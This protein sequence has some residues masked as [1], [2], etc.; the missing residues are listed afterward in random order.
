V[1]EEDTN[2]GTTVPFSAPPAPR[3]GKA[4]LVVLSG[5]TTGHTYEISSRTLIGRNHDVDLRLTDDMLSREHAVLFPTPDDEFIIQDLQSSNGTWVNGESITEYSLRNGDRIQIGRTVWK[6]ALQDDLEAKLRDAQRM[7]SVGALAAGIAHDFNNLLG[8]V[9][10]GVSYVED[11]LKEAGVDL[12]DAQ[13]MLD[14]MGAAAQR[15]A[16]LTRQLLSFARRG[17]IEQKPVDVTSVIEES[18]H[19][20]SRTFDRKIKIDTGIEAELRVLGDRSQIQQMLLNLCI[21]ARDAMPDGGS[22]TVVARAVNLDTEA[23]AMV[24]NVGAGAHILIEVGDTGVGMDEVTRSR[25]FEPFASTKGFGRG[26][27]LA[28]VHGIVR[29]H[30][31]SIQIHSALGKGTR[32][33][34]H[35]PAL[36]MSDVVVEPRRESKSVPI[37]TDTGLVLLVDDETPVRSVAARLLKRLGYEVIEARDGREAV[38]I[39]YLRQDEIKFVLLDL[40]MP[41][42]SGS[43]TFDQLKGMNPRVKV[44]LCSGFDDGQANA[45]LDRGAAAFL[46]KPYSLK[47]L[48]A[49]IGEVLEP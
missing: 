46:P 12:P 41:E 24:G 29:G 36:T 34:I 6:F 38:A 18:V 19:L 40:L 2:V 10:G 27:G 37:A 35:I 14:D 31:G 33:S 44:L 49:A 4:Y 20:A 30:S 8:V 5:G 22:L 48:R 26:L 13:T 15:A 11:V 16:E 21:N 3:R 1:G 43:E 7:E 17:E 47:A 32:F 25:A 39:Y 42:M 9:S 28:T 23:A 45:V